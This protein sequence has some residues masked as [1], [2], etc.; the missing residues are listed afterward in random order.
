[1]KVKQNNQSL[2]EPEW[3]GPF[4]C[5]RTDACNMFGDEAAGWR[6]KRCR[7]GRVICAVYVWHRWR[8][9]NYAEFMKSTGNVKKGSKWNEKRIR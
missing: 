6:Y 3:I 2:E 1:M 7:N 4:E 8:Y 9:V 5:L